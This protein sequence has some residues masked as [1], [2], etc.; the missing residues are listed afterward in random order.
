MAPG[1]CLRGADRFGPGGIL[2]ILGPMVGQ[3]DSEPEGSTLVSA[4]HEVVA[5]EVELT[6]VADDEA[7]LFAGSEVRH[8]IDLE[9]DTDYV[10][11]DIEVHTLPRPPGALLTLVATVNDVHFGET[12]CGVIDGTDLGPIL[13]VEEGEPPYPETMN[14]AAL[15]E[16]LALRDGAGP[17]AVVAKGDLTT[18]GTDE[19]YRQFLDCYQVGLGD[20][21][22]HVRGNHD[23]YHGGTFAA[24]APF[25]VTLPGVIL[26]VIDTTRPGHANGQVTT[27]DLQWLDELGS[28][29]DRPVLVFGHHHVWSPLSKRRESGYFGIV[30]DDSDRLIEV[31]AR[32][33]ALTGYFAGHTHR[34]RVRRF[35]ITGDFPWVEVGSTKDYPGA[36]AEYRVYEGGVLQIMRRIS[37]P[38]AIAWTNRTRAMFGGMYANYSFGSL[39][40][41]CFPVWPRQG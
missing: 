9:P 26:A 17:D 8:H 16:I 15:A 20:R 30:P 22:H 12:R 34:N 6:T 31:V 13:S 40:E 29:A 10:L 37:A 2:A 5:M 41:R 38:E 21:L 28:R 14:R 4:S 11:D 23:A 27:D 19:E 18:M 33:P 7:V 1:R 36:W 35:P 32:R 24:E 39:G 25:E 3:A